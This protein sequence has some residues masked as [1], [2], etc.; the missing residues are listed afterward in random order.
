MAAQKRLLFHCPVCDATSP[1]GSFRFVLFQ[2]CC[3]AGW[4]TGF[5]HF[6]TTTHGFTTATDYGAISEDDENSENS[7]AR[8]RVMGGWERGRF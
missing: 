4:D 7:V 3:T 8:E 5:E 1:Q 6:P 2:G